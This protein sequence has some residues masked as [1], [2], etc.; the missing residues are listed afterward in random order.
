M[1]LVVGYLESIYLLLDGVVVSPRTIGK[2]L[3]FHLRD[4]I[5]A[6]GAH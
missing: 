1:V 3:K 2:K 5:S 6:I 4:C